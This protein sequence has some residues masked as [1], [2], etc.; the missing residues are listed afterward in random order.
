MEITTL[1]E[2]KRTKLFGKEFTVPFSEI[3]A[4]YVRAGPYHIGL[5]RTH[6]GLCLI[7]K[8]DHQILLDND[9]YEVLGETEP[10]YLLLV[11]DAINLPLYS[12]H[13]AW[14][15]ERHKGAAIQAFWDD[16]RYEGVCKVPESIGREEHTAV[17][18]MVSSV[19]GT[20]SA[21]DALHEAKDDVDEEKLVAGLNRI[22]DLLTRGA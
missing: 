3:T 20:Y 15:N 18:N 2:G 5:A 4:Q 6:A 17:R 10:D 12:A 1:T 14:G 7:R 9:H 11:A 16:K 8:G 19:I 22:Y 21:R 13:S